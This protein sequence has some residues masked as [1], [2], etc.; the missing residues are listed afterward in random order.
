MSVKIGYNQIMKSISK[1]GNEMKLLQIRILVTDFKKSVEF[2]RDIVGFPVSFIEES[3]EYA[4][5]NNGETKIELLTRKAM[6]EAIG[7][8]Y[9]PNERTA[10]PAFLLNLGVDD[11]G[12]SYNKLRSKGIAFI[13]EP[14]DRKEWNA[15]VAHFR[16]PDGNLL[17]IYTMLSEQ[18]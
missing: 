17:E 7:E 6:A 3:M 9:N 18:Q 13:T 1:G 14:H 15:R 11:V 2:Y 16:D 4:L 12:D 5:F 8:E 10:Q